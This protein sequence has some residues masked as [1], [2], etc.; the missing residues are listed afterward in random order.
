M[1]VRWQGPDLHLPWQVPRQDG[2]NNPF[3][4]RK[5]LAWSRRQTQP[6]MPHALQPAGGFE[7]PKTAERLREG[8]RFSQFGKKQV[9]A[10]TL[11]TLETPHLLPPL[12]FP[13]LAP[14]KPT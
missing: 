2:G 6:R 5:R 8:D 11:E 7:R 3:S 1:P 4:A 12:A 14:K 9:P 13:L 10:A